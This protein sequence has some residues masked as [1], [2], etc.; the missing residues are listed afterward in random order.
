MIN[1]Y[2]IIIIALIGWLVADQPQPFLTDYG[3]QNSIKEQI[4]QEKFKDIEGYKGLYQVSN[5]GLIKSLSRFRANRPDKSGYIKKENFL[6][7]RKNGRGYLFTE[8]WKNNRKEKIYIHRLV[9]KYFISNPQ[10]K[11]Q[12]NHIDCNPS[13]NYFKNLEWTTQSENIK[14]ATKLGRMYPVWKKK[15]LQN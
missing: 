11:P 13:N 10:N 12:I 3:L 9:G 8:L 1:K 7:P 4:M 2:I 6:A 14:Y 15:Y 5:F